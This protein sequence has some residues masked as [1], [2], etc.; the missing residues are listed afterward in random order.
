MPHPTANIIKTM[1]MKSFLAVTSS[2]VLI[3]L[4]LL[5]STNAL[6][7]YGV[8]KPCHSSSKRLP[9]TVRNEPL[10]LAASNNVWSDDSDG[11]I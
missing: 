1:D 11:V 8:S 3:I 4:M 10:Y 9:L 5:T 7:V 2:I 6:C